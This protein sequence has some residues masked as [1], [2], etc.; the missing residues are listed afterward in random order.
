MNF[1][2]NLL[3]IESFKNIVII[4]ALKMLINETISFN[5]KK[6]KEYDIQI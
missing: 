5:I 1:L 3:I 4:I 2:H 6:K